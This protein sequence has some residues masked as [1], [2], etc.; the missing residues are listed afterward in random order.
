LD[1]WI[2]GREREI[3]ANQLIGDLAANS[4]GLEGYCLTDFESIEEI[5][6]VDLASIGRCIKGETGGICTG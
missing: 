4:G 5:G 1:V 2:G 6:Y 3:G